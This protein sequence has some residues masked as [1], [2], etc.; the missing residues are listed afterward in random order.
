MAKKDK[1]EV[2]TEVTTPGY[3]VEEEPK[4][5]VASAIITILIVLIWLG[6]FAVIVKTDI[7]GFGS[8]FMTPI[9]KDVPVLNKI[10]PETY[11]EDE[12]SDYH[13]K[14]MADAVEYI[15]QL[16]A[17]LAVYQED[18]T[19]KDELI[20]ELQ[21]ENARLK[22]FEERQAAFEAE[23]QAYY[24]EVVFGD[25]AIDYENYVKYYQEIEPD[26]A[27]ELYR[28]AIEKYSYDETYKTRAALYSSMDP[29]QAA[30]VFCEMTGDMDLVVKLLNSMN[31]SKSS[32]I[33]DEISKTDPVY[34]AKLTK[35]LLP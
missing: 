16:E 3:E 23:K 5:K 8:N 9:L 33:M 26:T 31:S 6:I 32:V 2:L 28:E 12:D 18:D 22:T 29:K 17:Q 13:Y 34:A 15:K 7:G 30:A 20:A 10:L 27:E 24:D 4:S 25:S 35:L 21:A 14:N 19:T 1:E 11:K